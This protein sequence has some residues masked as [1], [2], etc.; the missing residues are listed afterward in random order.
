MV[1]KKYDIMEH[2][3]YPTVVLITVLMLVTFACLSNM[4]R[5]KHLTDGD[6]SINS[7]YQQQSSQDGTR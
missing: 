7:S 4:H 1:P 3:F 5:N 6:K 2:Y